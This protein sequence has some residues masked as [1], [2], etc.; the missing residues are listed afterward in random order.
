MDVRRVYGLLPRLEERR[1]K[2][3]SELSGGEQQMLATGR[4]LMLTPRF[5]LL[6]EPLEGL[7][8]I[9]AKGL[10][11]R[12]RD[13][14]RGGHGRRRHRRAAREP[15]PAH[16]RQRGG[17]GARPAGAHEPNAALLRAPD[18]AERFLRVAGLDD[19]D[20]APAA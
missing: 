2:L 15:D 9:V 6:Y 1:L 3:G 8:P 13:D 5:L 12:S 4:V 16:H 7:A 20:S 11:G 10:A 18:A 17:P 14:R 19:A